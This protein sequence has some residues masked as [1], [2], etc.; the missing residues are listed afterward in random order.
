MAIHYTSK[1]DGGILFVTASG[2]DE[3]LE[4]VQSYGMG[5]IGLC[6]ESGVTHVL[7]DERA[8]E[9]RLGTIDTYQAG[10]FISEQAPAVARV[11][12]VCNPGF[13]SDMGFF[14]DVVV[15][16]G[17]ALHFFRDIDTAREW[18]S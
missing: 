3:N 15:N 7:C 5:I 1:V 17:L 10:K 9:Y 14:E 6:K 18:L 4:E 11:A 12:I 2:F 8:L 16:R 13:L